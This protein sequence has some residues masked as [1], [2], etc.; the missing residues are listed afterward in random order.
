MQFIFDV[1]GT[2]TPSRGKMDEEFFAWFDD[3]C[4]TESVYFVTGSDRVKTVEQVT[5]YLCDK[6]ERVYNCSGNEVWVKGTQVWAEDWYPPSELFDTLLYSMR[7][8][9]WEIMT[10]KHIEFRCGMINFSIVGRNAGK[11]HRE[12]YY[13]WDKVTG[14]RQKIADMINHM[15]PTI[16]A[17]VGGDTG[18]DI[19][20]KGKD[21]SQILKDFDASKVIFFGDRMDENG[22]DYPLA[23]AIREA[24]GQAIQVKDWQ[25][26]WNILKDKLYD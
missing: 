9:K 16:T 11:H 17:R 2:L 25:D 12:R 19:A 21:K 23:K 5:E 13:D 6:V 7:N 22:N 20:P 24:G 15:H 18:I 26:T 1:D 8:S 4:S 10:G 3:F 14:E